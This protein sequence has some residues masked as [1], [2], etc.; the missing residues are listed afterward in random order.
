MNKRPIIIT[1]VVLF[2]LVFVSRYPMLDSTV[3]KVWWNWDDS[4]YI[5]VAD[6]IRQGN[7]FNLNILEYNQ[8]LTK[9]PDGVIYH[10]SDFDYVGRP[11]YFSGPMYPLFLATIFFISSAQPQNWYVIAAIGNL[12]LTGFVV[13]SIYFLARRL[14]N[15]HIALI[16]SIVA[17]LLPSLYWYSIRPLPYP[18]LFL[19]V[20][21]A[22]IVANKANSSAGSK[23]WLLVG[24]LSA[25]AHLTHGSGLIVI[26][27]FLIWRITKR[28]FKDSLFLVIG[29][30]LLM[31]P[32][33]LRNQL[34]LG[35]FGLGL[36]IPSKTILSWFGINYGIPSSISAVTAINNFNILQVLLNIPRDSLHFIRC[37]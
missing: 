28:R 9:N 20:V 25:L 14:F 10:Y 12:V 3:N 34:L 1:L 15:S 32:W 37:G 11:Y 17:A 5:N 35:D 29:Y 31:L 24:A 18:L 6:N 13:I 36:A 27:T 30:L 22:F 16:A 23:W 19:F 7:G 33:M 2:V 26:L 21:L 8:V 4:Y